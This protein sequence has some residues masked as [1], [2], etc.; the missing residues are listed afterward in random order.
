MKRRFGDKIDY[1]LENGY[2]QPFKGDASFIADQ[3]S[4]KR[5]I[6]NMKLKPKK[7]H[8]KL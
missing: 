8:K 3:D 2:W 4:V 5:F 6:T 7:R 1:I